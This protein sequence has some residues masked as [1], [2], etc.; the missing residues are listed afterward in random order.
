MRVA[1]IVFLALLPPA[2]VATG[3]CATD[4]PAGLTAPAQTRGHHA[5]EVTMHGAIEWLVPGSDDLRAVCFTGTKDI[6]GCTRFFGRKLECGCVTDG[7]RWAM[8]GG[9]GLVPFMYLSKP[10]FERHE[11]L[12]VVEIKLRLERHLNE[13]TRLRFDS[14]TACEAAAERERSS[15][16]DLLDSYM[17]TSNL[18]L[19]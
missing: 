18:H 7:S 6:R 16:S 15:F 3:R 5:F 1:V 4:E 8:V 11:R 14:K 9:V 19:H 13:L 17:H 10:Y 12:H 2:A